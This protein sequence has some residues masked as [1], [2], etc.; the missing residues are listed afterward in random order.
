[1]ITY[2][3]I[4]SRNGV[5]TTTKRTA[6]KAKRIRQQMTDSLFSD[7][8]IAKDKQ[9]METGYIKNQIQP[10]SHN[11]PQGRVLASLT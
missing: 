8:S 7:Q 1:M 11:S 6:N 9:A 4:F 3:V 2:S 5:K 10:R